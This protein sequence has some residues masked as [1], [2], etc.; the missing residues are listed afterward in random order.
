M[1]AKE[2]LTLVILNIHPSISDEDIDGYSGIKAKRLVAAATGNKTFKVRLFC[3]N[4]EQKAATLKAGLRIGGI[5]YKAED[6]RITR[7]PIQCYN[8]QGL[9][10][11]ATQCTQPAK[12]MKCA[13]A[14]DTRQCSDTGT[15]A[16]ANCQGA[17]PSNSALCPVIKEAKELQAVKKITYA[18][19]TAKKA[20][21]V[22]SNRIAAV[23]VEVL[24]T[25]LEILVKPN[26]VPKP[27]TLSEIVA[28]SVQ[29]HYKTP[30]H[31]N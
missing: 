17:H 24:H 27:E 25:V 23:I 31:T 29:R 30:V 12:C 16:C 5:K 8:C 9:N 21:P 26:V 4:R 11:M 3:A 18:S 28:A 10:H 20:E 14:H 22:E 6:Y 13:G 1:Q 15:R 7:P 19:I 2:D